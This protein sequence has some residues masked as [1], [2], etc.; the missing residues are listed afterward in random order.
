M[1]RGVPHVAIGVG[2]CPLCHAEAPVNTNKLG[3][4]YMWCSTCR[5]GQQPKSEASSLL[6]LG[7]V[8]QWSNPELVAQMVEVEDVAKMQAPRAPQQPQLPPHLSHSN[9]PPKPPPARKTSWL[10]RPL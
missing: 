3:W 2:C 8:H 10:D 9:S 1:R 6:L 5:V 7:R 4:P